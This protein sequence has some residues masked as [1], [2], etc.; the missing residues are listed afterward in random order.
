MKEWR[1]VAFDDGF[2]DKLAW[3]VGCITAGTYVES[4]L[5]DTIEVDGLD[6]TPKI[7]S[8]I[9]K[10]KF[11][12]QL[13]CIFL[14]GITLGGFNVADIHEI[15]E[16]TKTPVVVVM[17]KIPNFDEIFKALEN[18]NGAEL[19]REIMKR[20][21][22]IHEISEGLY[23]Q[24]AGCNVDDAKLF[25]EASVSKGKIPEALRI[26]HLIA[27]AIVHKESKGRV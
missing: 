2:K 16:K 8:S 11:K 3:I 27:S 4:F 25:I 23:A 12:N 14:S 18:V 20:A 24:T 5:F 7:I 17:R 1:F 22:K 9:L 19:K 10:S 6:A 13:K 15:Y 21:G 26:A